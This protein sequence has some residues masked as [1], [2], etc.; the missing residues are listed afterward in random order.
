MQLNSNC[1]RSSL[2]W[3]LNQN[4]NRKYT[5]KAS[6]NVPTV[7][8]EKD[9]DQIVQKKTKK[10]TP[11]PNPNLQKSSTAAE[12]NQLEPAHRKRRVGKTLSMD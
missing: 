4:L 5:K 6:I 3:L 8:I 2:N 12:T 10:P 11:K 1:Q 7:V 9:S